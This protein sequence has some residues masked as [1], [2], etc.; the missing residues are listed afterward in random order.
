MGVLTCDRSDCQNIMCDQIIMDR[1][2][3]CNE[4]IAE[5]EDWRRT[6]DEETKVSDVERL[7][8]DF[9]NTSPGHFKEK[10]IDQTNDVEEEFQRL[11][12]RPFR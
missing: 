5:L 2:Y 12:P 1:M 10:P 9:M 8:S 3:I 4:C 11:G 7:L 6:W